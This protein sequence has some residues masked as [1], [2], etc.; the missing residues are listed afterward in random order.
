MVYEN[1]RYNVSWKFSW[2]YRN[3]NGR[4]IT[5]LK[6]KDLNKS[7]GKNSDY[8]YIIAE[9]VKNRTDQ[10]NYDVARLYCIYRGI[11][12]IVSSLNLDRKAAKVATRNILLDVLLLYRTNTKLSRAGIVDDIQVRCI[13]D[14]AKIGI[15]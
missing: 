7:N 3:T 8:E 1:D 15:V 4:V 9:S 6:C 14:L 12:Y 2:E 5:Y 11:P 13:N 10:I